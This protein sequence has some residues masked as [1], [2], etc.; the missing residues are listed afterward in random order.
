MFQILF[1]A[2]AATMM[3]AITNQSVDALLALLLLLGGVVGT[4]IGLRI[5]PKIKA[6]QLRIAL[7][8]MVL[9]VCSKLAVDLVRRPAELYSIAGGGS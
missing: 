8:V 3:H 9:A 2:A 1:V 6:E 5:G 7:A 4:Q